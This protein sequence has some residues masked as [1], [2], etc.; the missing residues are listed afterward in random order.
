[1]LAMLSESKEYP[2]KCSGSCN[3][4]QPAPDCKTRVRPRLDFWVR[5]IL[6]SVLDGSLR[7]P[8]TVG[9][10]HDHEHYARY[11]KLRS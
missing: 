10:S 9:V 11:A 8:I 5:V 7:F 2:Q 4:N 3:Y 6:G 1:M